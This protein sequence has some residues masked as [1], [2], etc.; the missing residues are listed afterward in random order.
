M[1][2]LSEKGKALKEG[3]HQRRLQRLHLGPG[4]MCMCMHIRL[5]K[6]FGLV[7]AYMRVRAGTRVCLRFV[8]GV[9]V[10]VCVWAHVRAHTGVESQTAWFVFVLAEVS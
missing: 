7:C 5:Q 6:T 4:V 1:F 10:R 3:I 2:H 8:Y 9:R